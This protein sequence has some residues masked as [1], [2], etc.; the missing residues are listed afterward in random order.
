MCPAYAIKARL[1]I[2]GQRQEKE[3]SED[4]LEHQELRSAVGQKGIDRG[5]VRR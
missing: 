3:D 1:C 2:L 5:K 4:Q